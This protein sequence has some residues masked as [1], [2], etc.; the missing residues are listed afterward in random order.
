MSKNERKPSIRFKGFNEVWEQ[1]K[2]DDI[3]K[4]VNVGICDEPSESGKYEVI[5]QGNVP[6]AG[7]TDL[8]P[9]KDYQ[10]IVLFGDHTLSI[11]KP[12]S[13]F[14]VAS[15][16]VKAYFLQN[17]EG[18]Y[19]AYLLEKNLPKY[20]GYKRYS[21]ILKDKEI[22][23]TFDKNEEIKIGDLLDNLDTVITLHQRKVESLS[24]IKKALLEKMFPSNEE[25]TPKIRFAGFSEAWE[26]HKLGNIG[27]TYTGLSG[28]SKDDF[29]HGLGRYVTYMNVFKNPIA[30]ETMTE[31]IE[32]DA[33]QREVKYGD[34]FFTTSSETPEEVGMSSIWLYNSQNTYLNSFCFGYRLNNDTKI[35]PYFLGYLLRSSEP[36]KAL[37]L[38]A[39]GISRFNISKTKVM[40]IQ[41]TIPGLEEEQC[42]IGKL[43]ISIDNL[44][45]LHQRKCEKL[46]NIKKALLEKMFV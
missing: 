5:Q 25:C 33:S 40:D 39:Q 17:V 28:K 32:V 18:N 13:P 1:R 15:D 19:F 29:G 23:L 2:V 24:N 26:Q 36:R 31:L 20:E 12:K 14:L 11:Y 42:K 22:K 8:E 21:S 9:C 43:M 37:Q 4:S 38:L 45:T 46:K 27:T 44:I 35:N 6:V 41:I 7:Y 34:V 16:G 3:I 30:D 10:P